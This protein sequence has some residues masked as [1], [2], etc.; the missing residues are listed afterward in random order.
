MAAQT[1]ELAH[2]ALPKKFRRI[3]TT[4]PGGLG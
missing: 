2:R 4:N 3:D 1:S